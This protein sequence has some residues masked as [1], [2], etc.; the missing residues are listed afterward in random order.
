MFFDDLS[1][2]RYGIPFELPSVLMIGWL[3]NEHG[4]P[5]GV[6]P[7]VVVEQ[8]WKLIELRS[9]LF[10]LH[11]NVVRGIH[12]C[13]LCGEVIKRGKSNGKR[14]LLGTSELWVPS[15]DKWFAS[16][17]LIVHYIEKHKYVPPKAFT[18]AVMNTEL[19]SRC[20]AQEVFELMCIPLM[21]TQRM[22]RVSGEAQG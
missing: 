12:P 17:T 18:D 22:E 4:F 10:D 6:V 2:Y 5:K 16:P 3:D 14:T 15:K 13:N 1:T 9:P 20:I 8:L 21:E 11:A 7:S 19:S